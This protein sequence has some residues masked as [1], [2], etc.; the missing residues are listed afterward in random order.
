MSKKLNILLLSGTPPYSHSGILALDIINSLNQKGHYAELIT[1][2]YDPKF[3]PGVKS[4]YNQFESKLV[5]LK[6]KI[7]ALF[8]KKIK[9]NFD[10]YIF[11]LSYSKKKISTKNVL[12][13]ISKKPDLIIYLFPHFFLNEENIYELY[14][15][16]RAPVI[17][18][19]V[20]MDPLT[21]GCH[22]FWDCEGFTKLC[23]NCPGLYS[24]DPHDATFKN[25]NYKKEF[26]D[27][28]EIYPIG[29]KYML[30]VI[31]KSFLYKGKNKFNIDLVINENLFYP[32]D[33]EKS[34]SKFLLPLD[35]KIIFFGALSLTERRKGMLFLIEALQL[36]KN[37]SDETLNDRIVIVMAGAIKD[38]IQEMIP[39]PI[40]QLGWLSQEDLPIA[41][42]AVDL[43]ICPSIEDA[44]P[45]MTI[46]SLMS[47]VPVV[48]FETGNANE[49]ITN[50][51]NGFKV[52][53]FNVEGLMNGIRNI[54]E[55]NPEEK[56]LMDLN[57]RNT[58][59]EKSSYNAFS[60]N[61]LSA[62]NSIKGYA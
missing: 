18:F 11:D 4:V 3:E 12:S 2:F 30:S 43:F 15:K 8:G 28:T 27:K 60:A 52:P 48:A 36:L 58:A 62:Y 19:P 47:G 59:L 25:M 55:M 33:V 24:N 40:F 49:M 61:I 5:K 37:S 44:G 57:C 54:L 42:R 13:K 32:G 10:Y 26:I 16:T 50:G 56:K 1:K 17:L 9:S 35:K 6:N 38:N 21:G 29:G 39:Y 31:N 14:N 45:M 7:F 41:F 23:G 20:D 53:I 22:Y 34:R 46:Q 51:F